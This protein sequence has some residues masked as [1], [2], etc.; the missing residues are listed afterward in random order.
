MLVF[1]EGESI[2]SFLPF[3]KFDTQCPEGA[4]L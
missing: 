4:N 2:G 1:A 3:Q